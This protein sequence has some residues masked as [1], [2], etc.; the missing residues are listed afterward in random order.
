MQDGHEDVSV[1]ASLMRLIEDEQLIGQASH[2]FSN[3]HTVCRK[4]YLCILASSL[5]KPY[6]VADFLADLQ[7]HFLSDSLSKRNSADSPRL[8]DDYSL[9]VWIHELRNLCGFAAACVSA[10]DDH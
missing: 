2:Q 6:I 4:D 9:E 10:N 5:L 8:R 3:S 1:D 7:S